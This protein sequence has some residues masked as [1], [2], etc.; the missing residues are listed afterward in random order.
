M[1]T[2]IIAI[3]AVIT[4]ITAMF[5]IGSNAYEAED[6]PNGISLYTGDIL[7]FKNSLVL[8]EGFTMDIFFSAPTIYNGTRN[9]NNIDVI[10]TSYGL[11]MR[12]SPNQDN[13]YYSNNGWNVQGGKTIT[14]TSDITIIDTDEINFLLSNIQT[15]IPIPP[16]KPIESVMDNVNSVW[17]T[18]LSVSTLVI[19]WLVANQIALC[20]LYL[21][22]LIAV[23]GICKRF[24]NAK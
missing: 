7:T 2:K 11:T 16:Q 5:A 24:V 13:V 18:T 22:I 15:G 14:I 10:S 23:I 1:K 4:V 6:Y 8:E 3:I 19:T 12:Y 20:G 9:Y 21:Y 17:T